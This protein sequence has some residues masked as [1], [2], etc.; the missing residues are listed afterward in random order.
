MPEKRKTKRPGSSIQA[1]PANAPRGRVTPKATSTTGGRYTAPIPKERK[2]SPKWVP[3]SMGT[4][5]AAGMLGIV[6]NYIG[7][8][9][10][11][12]SNWY[13][14]GGLALITAGFIVA[15]RWR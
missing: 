2:I 12:P 1:R 11:A 9:P 14:I 13:L 15:T 3:I 4:L 7:L 5:L 8:L 6:L 10:A